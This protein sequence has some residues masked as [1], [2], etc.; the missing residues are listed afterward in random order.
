MSKKLK[1]STTQ[2]SKTTAGKDQTEVKTV[3]STPAPSL[4][5]QLRIK[6]LMPY[7][8]IMLGS[9]LLYANTFSYEYALDDEIVISKNEYVLRGVAGMKDIFSKDLFDSFYK[10]MNTTAQLA[11]G[12]YRPLSVASFAIEQEFIGTRQDANFETNCW[13]FNHNGKQ[14]ANEDV[15]GDGNFNDKDLKSKGFGF[16]HIDNAIFYGLAVCMLFL[17]LQTIVFKS[18]KTLSLMIALLFL[19]HPIHTEVVANVKSRDEIFSF[20]FILLSLIMAHRYAVNRTLKNLLLTCLSFFCALLSKEYGVVLLLLIPLSIWLFDE[21]SFK[22]ARYAQLM[23]GLIVCFG[24]YY[25]IRSTIVIGESNLQDV[26]LMNNPYLLADDSQKLATKLFIFMKYFITLIFPHPLSSDYGYNSIP[27]KNFSDFKVWAAILFLISCIGA[28]IYSFRNKHWTSF[29]IAFYMLTMLLVTN[30][31]FNIG[32]TMGERLAFHASLG[33]CML[34]GY[35][36]YK[37]GE[38]FNNRSIG[39]FLLIP[40]LAL[41]SFKT[42]S[43]NKAWKNDITLA[44]TDVEIM[45]ESVAL[46]GNASSRNLDLSEL[47]RNKGQEKVLINKA[48]MYG[49]KAV[50]LHPGF[51]N[52]YLNLGLG[53]AKLEMYDSAKY[54]WDIAFKMYPHHP[55]KSIYYN[56]LASVYYQKGLNFA[57]K[58]QWNE[59][60]TEIQ[61]AVEL[62]P[63]NA[64]Y[65]YDL[66]G[67]SYNSHDYVKAKEAWSKA[68]QL[69]PKD[70]N[71]I[72]VQSL[73]H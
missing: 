54:V 15:N 61:K 38:K 12:R 14:D 69:N 7:F 18:N 19:A 3:K 63:N 10:Q 21:A 27:Y 4:S 16:R 50:K 17:F 1:Q 43:R 36:I 37:I 28:G 59:G 34:L 25:G 58:A 11:G 52:G 33:F 9:I 53:Y 49:K 51:V 47:P 68:Y 23:V 41:Y 71:I 40:I 8:V 31:V 45:P 44:L 65:W 6:L 42:Y 66:G 60:K 67:F 20:L 13:D 57:K 2:F 26:E 56:L 32:A 64:R 55:S 35:G 5:W 22:P 62:D 39:W 46:N 70:S 73:L 24:I 48:I 72:K 29:A 30:L